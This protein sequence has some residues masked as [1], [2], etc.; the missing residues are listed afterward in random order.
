MKIIVSLL[1]FLLF[2]F[3]LNAGKASEEY[4]SYNISVFETASF[5]ITVTY[6]CLAKEIT[7]DRMRYKKVSKKTGESLEVI[8]ST[9][10]SY[11]EGDVPC[12][13]QGYEFKNGDYEYLI[14]HDSPDDGESTLRIY[15]GDTRLLKEKGKWDWARE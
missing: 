13:F 2:S 5:R 8:G 1:L 6:T 3:T 11:C 10:H 12:R 4:V 7:C 9:V 15:Q 14:W